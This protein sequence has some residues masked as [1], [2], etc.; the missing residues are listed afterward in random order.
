MDKREKAVLGGVIGAA[1][2]IGIYEYLKEQHKT[3]Q[4][5]S[6]SQQG[7]STTLVNDCNEP[8]TV[9]YVDPCGNQQTVTVPA[10]SSV[11]VQVKPNSTLYFYE[12]GS[13]ITALINLPDQRILVCQG[14]WT[15]T[16]I[17]YFSDS[18]TIGYIQPN[19]QYTT[20]T[21]Q[22]E[23]QQIIQVAAHSSINV[24]YKGQTISYSICGNNV[25][26]IIYT[27]W[28]VKCKYN[29]PPSTQ[30]AEVT[31]KLSESC[32]VGYVAGTNQCILTG[33]YMI[34]VEYVDANGV[35]QGFYM[36]TCEAKINAASGTTIY[37]EIISLPSLQKS[38]R[39]YVARPGSTIEISC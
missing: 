37:V 27:P 34:Y 16:L 17:N 39:T 12:N 13:K 10:R 26:M 4:K 9:Y 6:C 7:Y 19:Q 25:Y 24:I 3:I 21:L 32:G 23:Q 2:A 31:L 33:Q 8:T 29:L 38:V 1:L 5:T 28:N 14:T 20:I 22:P 35:P 15:V 18:V 36:Q 11:T 30:S